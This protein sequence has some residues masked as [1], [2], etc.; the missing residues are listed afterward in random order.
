MNDVPV[1]PKSFENVHVTHVPFAFRV[2]PPLHVFRQMPDE[3]G[4]APVAFMSDVEHVEA[5]HPEE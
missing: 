2:Y 4:A 3:S 1:V 5:L